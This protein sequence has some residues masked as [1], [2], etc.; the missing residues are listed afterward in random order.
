MTILDVDIGN[1]FL[2]WRDAGAA[3]QVHRIR[4]SELEQTQ[5]P[6]AVSRVRVASVAGESTNQELSSFCLQRWGVEPEF[7]KTVSA[8]AGVLNSYADPSRMGVDRWLAI[9]SAYHVGQKACWV[10]DCGSAITVEQ[11]GGDGRHI[12]GYI[13]PGLGDAGDLAF[14]QKLQK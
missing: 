6:S 13:I 10:V 7:A 9:L 12:G 1:T 5:L 4:T 3:A 14:G 8:Q 11:I 2:K